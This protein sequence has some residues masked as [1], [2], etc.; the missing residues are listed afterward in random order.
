MDCVIVEFC[1]IIHTVVLSYNVK[2]TVYLCKYS[3]ILTRSFL[4]NTVTM[5]LAIR[6]FHFIFFDKAAPKSNST[7]QR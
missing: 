2:Y 3:S 4:R 5:T 6:P 7:I 1:I